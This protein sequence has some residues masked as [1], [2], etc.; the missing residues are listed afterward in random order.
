MTG[1]D[2]PDEMDQA[3]AIFNADASDRDAM[4]LRSR[5][6]ITDLLAGFDLLAPGVVHPS[7]WRPDSAPPPGHDPRNSNFYAAVATPR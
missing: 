5:S 1:D 7:Q 4:V 3:V 6:E 2:F